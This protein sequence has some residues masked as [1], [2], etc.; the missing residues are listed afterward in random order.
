[1][2]QEFFPESQLPIRK[3]VELL[4]QIFQ[5]EANSKFL[6]AVVDPLVQPGV[7]EKTVGY[8]GRRY[9]KTY[10]G[11]DIYLDSDATLRSRYQLEPGVI[12]KED[13]VIKNFY[14]YLD[15]KN[16]IK[17]FG[18]TGEFDAI[19][20][21]QEHYSWN[22]PIDWDKFVNYRE[23]YW[24]PEGP[25]PIKILGQSQTVT[26]TYRVGLGVGSVY[27]FT[28][29]G[30]TNNPTL[31]LYR[32]QT[33]KFQ[34]NAPNNGFLI[35]TAI[36]TGT[37]LYNP[38]V[39]Y[40]KGQLVVFD[41][42]LWR[43]KDNI[44][45]G[46]GSTINL[47]NQDWEFVDNILLTNSLDYT[48]GITNNGIEN[49]TVTFEVPF[50]AP[51]VLFYQ[52]STDVN[53]FGRFII[54]NIETNTKIDIEKEIIG[55]ASYTSSNNISLSN[56]MLLYFV[57]SVTP[58]RY[59]NNNDRWLV[60][61]VG[62]QITLTKFSDLIVSGNLNA[63]APEILFDN[64]GFDSQP[65]D[66]AS[67]YPALKDYTTIS[68][69]SIDSNPWS[70]YNRWF[71][72]ETLDFSHSF[73]GTSFEAAETSRAK[74]PIIEFKSN[75][76]LFNHGSIAKQTVD[77][78]DNFTTDIFS[79]IEGS[80]GYIVDGEQLFDGARV[81]V[82]ADTD[83]LANNKIYVV[84]FI[85]HNNVTQIN[86]QKAD[87][88]ES[89]LGESA[90]IRRGNNY[91]GLMYHFNGTAWIK[92]QLK[93]KVN[94]SPLFDIFDKELV[95]L[96][97]VDKYPI[98]SF[99]GTELLSYVIGNSVIDKELGFSLSYLNIDNVGD[100]QFEFDL[101][102][103]QFTYKIAQTIYTEN[104][105]TGYYKFNGIV[106]YDNGWKVLDRT[107]SQPIIDSTIVTEITNTIVS[108]AVDWESVLETDINK[109]IFYVNGIISKKTWTRLVDTFT[110]SSKFKVGDVVTI[111]IF[112]DLDPT[113]GYYEIPLGLEKNPL[114]D[115]ITSFT[116]G[117][118]SDHILTGIEVTDEFAGIYP[119]TSNLR[120]ISGYENKARRF[121][122]HSNI[123]PLAA[124]LLCDKEINIVKSIQYAKKSYTD[125]KNT[126]VDIAYR[127]YYDQQPL[128][129]V[130][131]I[132]E[133]ISKTQNSSRPFSD[134]DMIGSGAYSVLNYTVE[135]EGIKT[136]ALSQKFD[137]QT[138]SSKAVYV[139]YNNTQ[140]LTGRDYSFNSTFG[141]VSLSIPLVE[142]DTIEIREYV[143][144]SSN[145]IPPT[146]TKLGLYRKYEPKKFLDN[147]YVVPKEVIQGHDGSITIAYGDFRDDILLELEKRIYNNIKQTYDE[148]IFDNDAILGGY[149]G[150]AEYGKSEL[151]NIA[152]PEFLKW[153]ADTNID[154]VNNTFFDSENSFTY[155]YS[156][157]VDPSK[158]K[159]LP[160]YWRGVYKWF[161]DTDRPHTCPWEM[162]GF[163]EK[164]TWWESE[165]GPAP[166]TSNNLILWEDLRDGV[167]RQGERAGTRDRYKRPSIMQHIPVDGDGNLLSP[168]N[169][170][171]AGN[172]T[173]INNK[174]TFILGDKGPVE[175][176]WSASSEW[177]F[178][179]VLALCLLKP[180]EYIT[181]TFNKSETAL[182][183]LG[184]TINKTSKSFARLSDVI[185]EN[186]ESTPV[187][188]LVSYVVNYLKSK[189]IPVSTLVNKLTNIDVALSNRLSGFVDQQQQKYV[190][191]S[192]NPKSTTSSVFVP[193][194]N[195]DIIFNVSSPIYSVA[196]SGII[197]EKTTRGWKISGYDTKD[198]FFTYFKPISS[199]SDPLIAVGG[200]SENF[201]SWTSNKFYGN[202]VIV[203][204]GQTYFRSLRS[205]TSNNTFDSA[206]WKQLSAL[207]VTG[208]V[209][210]FK[211]R[212]YNKLVT[213]RLNYGTLMTSI[214]EVV[215]FMLGYQEY[216]ISIG[217]VF[218]GYDTTIQASMD[219]FTS[220]KEFMFWSKHNWSEG[221][222]LTLSPN[223]QKINVSISL[224]VADSFLDS[225]YDY[226][227]LQDDGTPL[228]PQY[229]NVS[230]DYKNLILSTTNT[231]RGIYF[232][233]AN[234]V[235][236]EHIVIFDDRTVFND[237]MYDKPTGYRQERIKSRGFRTV[238]W[239]GDYTS[240]GFL[241]DNV[242]IA[243]WQ[244]FTDYRLGDIVAHKSYNWTSKTNQ[245]GTQEFIDANWTKLDS[246]PT[247][248]L[249]ANFD[250]RINQFEDYYEVEADGVGSSQRELARHAIGYQPREYLQGLAE[251]E[252]SQFRLYQGFIREKGTNNAVTKVFDKLSRTADDSVVLNEEWAF[253]VGELGGVEQLREIEFE[254]SKESIQINPQPTL[255]VAEK[256]TVI[257]D[258]NL[259]IDPTKF[260]LA[261]LPFTSNI[262]PLASFDKATRSAG[263][264]HLNDID[265]VV[266]IRDDILNINIASVADND[267]FW[268]T[269]DSYKWTVLRYN[270]ALSL[271]IVSVLKDGTD[272]I[273][274]L[275]RIHNLSIG[276]IIGIIYVANLT[277]FYKITAATS[278]T[279]TVKTTS[280]D[281]PAIEDSA[282]A[283]IGI[284]TE[285]KANTYQDLD[286]RTTA[287]LATGSKIWID[288]NEA[289]KWEVVEKIKQYQTYDLVDYGITA[290]LN[291]GTAI[292]YIEPLKQIATSLPASGYVMIYTDRTAVNQ[293]LGLK[294]MVAPVDD[295]SAPVA[296]VFG[297]VIAVSPDYKWLAIASPR[298]TAVPSHYIG[299]YDPAS[300]YITGSIV[301]S[302]GKL[303]KAVTNVPRVPVDERDDGSSI[304]ITIGSHLW[305]P[306]TIVDATPIG[307]GTGFVNQGMISLY[308]YQ[309]DQWENVYN[310]VSPRPATDERFGSSVSFGVSGKTYYMAV[311][312]TGSMCDPQIG[313]ATGRGR[314]YMYY[315]NGVTWSHHENTNYLGIYDT[316]G[317]TVYPTGSV[318]W[319]EDS[320]WQAVNETAGDGSSI[321]IDSVDWLKLDPVSTSSSLPT[322]V[323]VN[324]DGST[325]AMGLLSTSQQAELVKDGDNFGHSLCMS[326][327]ASVLVVGVPNSDGQ[328]FNNYKG[329]WNTY[330]EYVAN[331][332]VKYQD[333]YYILLDVDTGDSATVSKNERP[334]EGSP[335]E[336]TGDS[337]YTTTGKV[338]VYRRNT[339]GVYNL[340][341]TLTAQTLG[342]GVIASGD[343]F[344]TAIDIDASGT[345]LVVTSPLADLVRENQGA[346]YVF[347][348]SATSL[349]FELSQQLQ[350]YENY[351]NEYFGT[352]VSISAATER[353]VIG[354]KDAGYTLPTTFGAGTEFD[355]RRTI[356]SGRLRFPGQVYVYERKDQGYFLAEKLEAEFKA[357][358]SFGAS[359]DCTNSVIAVGSPTYTLDGDEI[360]RVRLFKK[361]ANKDSINIIRSQ[362]DL[363]DLDSIKNIELY[364]KQKN[365]KIADVDII[366]HYKLKILSVAEEDIKFKTVYDPATYIKATDN[367]TI[368]ET[369]AWL[370]NHVGEVWWDLSTVKFINA[371]QDELSY[372][373]GNWST[374]VHGS[375][376]DVY[377][378]VETPLLPSEWSLL[379]DT[380]EGL[381][382]SISGQPKHTDDT[383]YNTKILYNATTG[384]PTSTM[385]YY[386]VKNKTV[387]PI[388]KDRRTSVATI[389]SY[390]DSPISTGIPFVAL[391]G[392]DK[393]AFYNF[394]SIISTDSV[395]VN[396]EYNKNSVEA[397]PVHREYQLLTEG[398]AD[399]IPA[400]FLEKKWIDSLVGF[401]E[402][403]NTVPDINLSE[404][405]RYGLSFRPRQT[406]FVNREKALKIVIDNI[407]AILLT[408]PF[409]DTI[410]FK[411][412]SAT[413][414]I[415]SF[416]LNRYDLE[417]N[418]FIDLEQ[419]GT[420]KVRQAIFSVNII[421]GEVDTIDIIDPGFG[422]RTTPY[423]VI[424][425][426]GTGAKAVITID[427][428]GRVN[429]ITVTN[430]GKKYLSAFVKI[431]AFSVLVNN[432][433]SDK[434]FWSIYSWDQQ[435]KI[436]Y[437]SRTQGY[438][439]K[440]YWEYTD[441]WASGFNP[442]SRI[443]EEIISLYEEPTV[444]LSVGAL[445]RV[446]EYS[447]GGW[448]VL[449]KTKTG[450]GNLLNNYN[451]V[452]RENGTIFIKDSLYNAL[453]TALGY[454]NVGSYDVAYYDLQPI[455][456]LRNIL[457]A[458]KE[459][460][461]VDDLRVEWNKL[462]FSSVRYAFSEQEYIDWAFKTSFLNAIHNVGDLDQRPNYK[463]DNL[464]QFRNYIEEVKPYRTTIREY[465]SRYTE[466]ENFYG[467]TI[468]FDLPPAYSVRDGKILPV[469]AQYNRFNEYP[470]KWWADNN[471]YSIT[472]IA[473][474][475]A[476]SNYT[477]PPKVIIT[478]NGTGTTATAFIANG[479]V[480]GIRVDTK[481]S[482]YTSTPIVTLVGGNG[483]SQDIATAA[484]IIG[485]TKVRSFDLTMKFDRITKSGLYKSFTQSQT[486]IATGYSAVFNLKYAPTHDKTKIQVIKNGTIILKN[487]YTISLYKDSI[488]GYS[489]LKGKL[490]FNI[491][492]K[493]GDIIIIDYDKN[494][495]Y[496]DAV[497]RIN[498][499]YAPTAGMKGNEIGQLMTGIDF[500]GVQVQGTTFDI[501]GGWDALPWFTDSWDSVES[502]SDYH[503]VADG[504]TTYVVL[505]YI[506]ENNSPISIYLK[507]VDATR[508]VRIDDPFFLVYDGITPQPNGRVTA[509]DSALMPT[510]VGDGSTNVIQLHDAIT[511][512]PYVTVST[513][514]VLIF[515][516]LDSDGSVTITDVNLLDTRISGGSLSNMGGA[517]VTATGLTPEEIVIDGDKFVTPDQ[518]PAPEENVPGQVLDS[519][520]IKVFTSTDPGSTP[521]QSKVLISNGATKIFNI[522]LS[523]V[524]SKSVIV[525]VDK[526]KQ[527]NPTD[528]IINFVDNTIEFEVPPAQGTIIEIISI[529]RGGI[530]LLDYQEFVADGTTSLFLTKA[531]Y[532]Q[533]ASVLVTV[534]GIAID[535]GFVNSGEFIDTQDKT[536]VQFGDMP[537]YRQVVKIICFGN[538]TE[539]DS[540]GYPFVRI[541]QQTIV[542]DGSTRSFDLDKF[543]PLSR[544]SVLSAMLVEVNGV[545][546]TGI[547]TTYTVYNGTNNAIELGIDPAEAIG[548]ITSGAIKVYINNILQR[549]VID[550]TYN[551]NLNL[552]EI[553]TENLSIEDIIR[554]ETSTRTE[555]SIVSG[556]IVIDS[557]VPLA[558]DDI[559]NVT[560]FSEYP[561]MDIISD[562]YTGG[563]VQY[564]LS[565][566]PLSV[567]YVWVYKNGVRL[568]QDRDYHISS[569][570]SVLYL[571]D[572]TNSSDKIKIV[573]FGNII[574]A[575]PRAFEIFKDMLNNYHYKRY[576]KKNSVKLVN[577]VNY[578]DTTIEVTN[579]TLLPDPLP[580]RNIP[581]VIIINNERIEYF[582]KT[583]NTISQLRRGSLGTAIAE[584][585]NADSFVIN[586]GFTETLPYTET[587]ERADFTSDG[588]TILVGPLDFIPT[589]S[590][591]TTWYRDTIPTGYGPC[592]TV[593]VFVG[594]KRLIKNPMSIYNED[595][596]I[597][598]PSSDIMIEAEFSVDG[599]SKYI[600]LTESVPAGT[601]IT[602]IRKQGKIWYDR[603]QNTPSKGISLLSNN[604]PVANFIANSSTEL[605]E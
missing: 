226:Q 268:V 486:F 264:V 542:Y 352:S 26:S 98:S 506:P 578:Y 440:I 117:Q 485:D 322:N 379:A 162:L 216:L 319:A 599:V 517:Y 67:A 325:L 451:L 315:Y 203:K 350:T 208:A 44:N 22:P 538:S 50:D 309:N 598:S 372:R 465:T 355:S 23:Y 233:R 81:L 211:R 230:R 78:I 122:K 546:L 133:E 448:A 488:D 327:D 88:A 39:S 457:K 371:E 130:D 31:T 401:D 442:T 492:P 262:T 396:I 532:S 290:P 330:Q 386:W 318:V 604:T 409:V 82:T 145:F 125:F 172:F 9:G 36:D 334:D 444:S 121:L 193:Q 123:A 591:R 469:S 269:F 240:P 301:L 63:T 308:K 367:E 74:R 445:L 242:N 246:T 97:D 96:S 68:K 473:V 326:R 102:K 569:P 18:N 336:V 559:I 509:P 603:G 431:R 476:G 42:K 348:Y 248:G 597:S 10:N 382:E 70:R 505:P 167:I 312:A 533:T 110:F 196:Y 349:K 335:W 471:G 245:L 385:Y 571:T 358:E 416:L 272:V 85:R 235:L 541:N 263:P 560:W 553:S 135:D 192:K 190:L 407:N 124:V 563:K 480:S 558:V 250:Y 64:G 420:V 225:F 236:K 353:I 165:Y 524:E 504:S 35:K 380:V 80:R 218:D 221:S 556:N 43:A 258:Q 435:R 71:H 146:P 57:G 434:G 128:D 73:N 359:V 21:N 160:G 186:S 366:D 333:S 406:M 399:N 144:T 531:L 194:E 549:F 103:D 256:S 34:I 183:L 304:W 490:G 284:F 491:A 487:E 137:L 182:N 581:G 489:V 305:E 354:A 62:T 418:N 40:T 481:G 479:K 552:I 189:T 261:P 94:Q 15:F 426:T 577:D 454:D 286:Y 136:F 210:A 460:I 331:D 392:S 60:E 2:A 545:Q 61:G 447:N 119:G 425:G 500:G 255:I 20:T 514:D 388:N 299:E 4:P 429:S 222:L 5:T 339:A 24:V 507:R 116:L 467:G 482:G 340:T 520:S 224:G 415:P 455:A 89:I 584:K 369:Q 152:S 314:V 568:T 484:A 588:S 551:G 513:G 375:S 389:A 397:N 91:K 456:E 55:K 391:L 77:Y 127:L 564:Q 518:V 294:Q 292:A 438:D 197:I 540:T 373:V 168:L 17:F 76:Q 207:P 530:G 25:P 605:P 554:I 185:F 351:T 227:I 345:T 150:N 368:D 161:Y 555:F 394:S 443:A 271:R 289:G 384:N 346:A 265:F 215:D 38:L 213:N 497:N 594:G 237:V 562:E 169:S 498:K 274:S 195:Y 231:N 496:L 175:A 118:A 163:S 270:E 51:D 502:N 424:E 414:S 234:F 453:T 357:Y 436:F 212:N 477:S 232:I 596:G 338:F 59:S 449:E 544:G 428:Q 536:M 173:L 317:A 285:A 411:N 229:I 328:F 14:D 521:L 298:A 512:L 65:Y 45:S 462:F 266:K 494:D 441:W 1:M 408:R 205:H 184:Q 297:E 534:D 576:S 565:R 159:N 180:F 579:G 360:G 573:Q 155:T 370:E 483:T 405:Q 120:N 154:Y 313:A 247:K 593:E 412:L 344:G 41:E 158:T 361:T 149:Y 200:V 519:L 378:W 27:L 239:D 321:S 72:R 398:V 306:A 276:D 432:D 586:V 219:W 86:L 582:A 515:R 493:A 374:Q 580:I 583:E 561:T 508:A 390:I 179:V 202:G 112:A 567:N 543:V 282:S 253:K 187:S 217:F 421:N 472:S 381:A 547:D 419:V 113:T 377:E 174:G 12:I 170:G 287:L 283:V 422:Y 254:I 376:V 19:T 539:T 458:A 99:Q 100:I 364:N 134:S 587:Q 140:L 176:A 259:R 54:G 395:L 592:D 439:T 46:D 28:P 56:G 49:G 572:N 575:P 209:Q 342:D 108:T 474:A 302:D 115:K 132:L 362:T 430:R 105:F 585:H 220:A 413:D 570:R 320:L 278:T 423:I 402:A 32:G 557:A 107:L 427:S 400:E 138:L 267:H 7:L 293:S 87:D 478:G 303:W 550:Y 3:T 148:T 142:G 101:D 241:F 452:G 535:T 214:Q 528:Y 281:N 341:Q 347:K 566:T 260:T 151:D 147:T 404:K 495:E 106:S 84:R 590:S 52:S 332:V 466:N 178:A 11:K 595:L 13:G 104:I 601:R 475:N 311:S 93:T 365:L 143:S 111:K 525:Y 188:G 37:L 511:D 279:I 316:T 589:Q 393:L 433:S 403:G 48:K 527:E 537:T 324:D 109:I 574:Y 523:I 459:D 129:Y 204:Y 356:F 468:D 249:V 437:R 16:Q 383:V 53:K 238:D 223:S 83:S 244:P 228:G 243:V 177:P 95:S 510:F 199:Q 288:S 307:Q 410:N 75:L 526:I 171:L 522:G 277:G 6:S 69:S 516:K 252:I 251:D 337:T 114:N 166:Y 141:F 461:F 273:L 201:L 446:K 206:E 157:M 363:V 503:Y 296:G 156:N 499:Y 600:R 66:D 90:L 257:V 501:T 529:G 602:I 198:P 329:I 548:T 181:D 29:D 164:P 291:T 275:S 387:L 139:Y 300:E 33:Y 280:S 463:N 92:S 323:S 343:K 153:I 47:E 450:L 79:V 191:D 464:D 470:W 310:F 58:T 8:I 30:L 417:V 131:I 126:F 295:L